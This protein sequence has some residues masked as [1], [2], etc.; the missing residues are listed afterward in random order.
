MSDVSSTASSGSNIS[1]T[2][3]TALDVGSGMD[4]PKLALDLTN[5]EKLPK[6]NA[7]NADIKAS[8]AAVSGYALVSAKVK[9]LQTAFEAINDADELSTGTGSS[10]D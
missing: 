6:Q 9:Q 5:A 4:S 10:S 3:F 7:I 1:S 8:E 2:I